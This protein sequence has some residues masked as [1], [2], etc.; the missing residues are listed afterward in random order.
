MNLASVQLH[1]AGKTV[2]SSTTL[3]ILI[4]EQGTPLERQIFG[5]QRFIFDMPPGGWVSHDWEILTR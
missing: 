3:Q 5:P 4:T 2:K 1:K